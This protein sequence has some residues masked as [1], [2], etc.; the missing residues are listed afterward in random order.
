MI[1]RLSHEIDIHG[2]PRVFLNSLIGTV[3]N[4]SLCVPGHSADVTEKVELE[5]SRLKVEQALRENVL[6]FRR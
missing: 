5:E 3:E 4:D 6:S 1:D 2:D